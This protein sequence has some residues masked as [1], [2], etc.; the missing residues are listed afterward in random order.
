M[1]KMLKLLISLS[2]ILITVLLIQTDCSKN[3]VDNN[4]YV[5]ETMLEEAFDIARQNPRM[6]SIIVS[7]DE[8]IV[9]E[10]YYNQLYKDYVYN[11]KSVTKSFTSALIGIAIEKGFIESVDQT[12]S[13]YISPEV[14][15]YDPAKADISIHQLLTMS[16]GLEW[17]QVRDSTEIG[18]WKSAPNQIKYILEKPMIDPPGQK[19][20]YSDGAP[21]LL[22]VILTKAT[23]MKTRDF[24]QEYLFEPLGIGERHWDTDKQSYN[25]GGVLLHI[26]PVDML[27]FG[28]LY[29][30]EGQYE[31]R[32]IISSDWVRRSGSPHISTDTPAPYG[33]SYGY[34]WWIDNIDS[35]KCYF[36]NGYGGQLIFIMPDLRLVVVTTCNVS[37]LYR[38]QAIEQWIS[39]YTI[40]IEHI[41]P[42]V[43]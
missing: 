6:R 39:I 1:K 36:A 43:H 11:V 2:F 20:N 3:S 26:S 35:H 5:D 15:A 21:H 38:Y 13:D 32:Q 31:G 4:H 34:L 33:S 19:F 28:H 12:L 16:Y 42:A 10:E 7:V 37:S 18:I 27:K 22:S 23:G 30:N 8:K 29:L 41:V 25:Y 40:I 24:A 9:A 17:S 14:N